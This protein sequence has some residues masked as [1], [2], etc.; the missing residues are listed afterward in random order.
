MNR[1]GTSHPKKHYLGSLA[2]CTAMIGFILSACNGVP[3]P[4][5]DARIQAAVAA[6]LAS[7]PTPSPYPRPTTVPISPTSTPISL[8]DIFCEYNF[9]IGHPQGIY[10]L[11]QGS[12]RQPPVSSTYDHGVL[13]GYSPT[14]F[15]EMAWTASGPTFDPQTT[16]RFI[17]EEKESLQ[18]SL[19]TLLLGKLN[20]FYQS[21]TTVSSSLPFGGIASWQCGGRDFAWKVY[22]PQDGMAAALIKQT[23]EKFRCEAP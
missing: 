21:M 16:M 23:L 6:T 17:V 11:D 5:P 2:A 4:S 7:I 15:I 20:V 22:T 1:R 9:C 8:K 19:N 3:T 12:T 18:G 10:L 14:L 13:F